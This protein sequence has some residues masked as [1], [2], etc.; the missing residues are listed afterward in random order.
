MRCDRSSKCCSVESSLDYAGT[1]GL[2]SNV[3]HSECH[4]VME[5]STTPTS[6]IVIIL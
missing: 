5:R 6:A 2:Q 3:C 4:S 1:G